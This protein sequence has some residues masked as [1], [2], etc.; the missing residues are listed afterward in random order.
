M[1]AERGQIRTLMILGALGL[2][3]VL[4]MWL[5]FRAKQIQIEQQLSTLD[6]DISAEQDDTAGLASIGQKIVSLS[7]AVARFDKTVPREPELA[8]LLRELTGEL[9]NQSVTSLD[10]VPGKAVEGDAYSLVPIALT[11]DGSFH[12]L[13]GFLGHIESMDRLVQINTINAVGNPERPGALL[14]VRIQLIAFYVPTTGD[15]DG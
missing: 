10:I 6:E 3:F 9:A 4:A 2:T 13:F 1:P 7:H 14:A 15:S 8:S 5:P 12:A 11:F